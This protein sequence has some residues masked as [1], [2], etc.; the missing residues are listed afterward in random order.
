MAR[1][2]KAEVHG[3]ADL[4]G[5]QDPRRKRNPA[6]SLSAREWLKKNPDRAWTWAKER[7]R[8]RWDAETDG[9]SQTELHRYWA[10]K[11]IDTQQCHYCEESASEGN[12]ATGDHVIPLS[13]GGTDT[14]ENL[15]P[16]CK[17]C[18][19]SKSDK[20]INQEWTPPRRRLAQPQ[21]E[22]E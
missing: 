19:S 12:L 21:L 18:N 13:R 10:S 17:S 6:E 5:N 4:W 7:R 14:V 9:H 3:Q 16:C 2:P 11:G 20:L 15:V 1:R 8:R 22:F